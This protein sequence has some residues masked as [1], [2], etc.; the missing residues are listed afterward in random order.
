MTILRH[1]TPRVT[2]TPSVTGVGPVLEV[3]NLKTHFQTERGMVHAVDGVSLTAEPGKVVGIVGESGSGKT[4]L[5]RS[6]MGLLPRQG[7]FRSGEVLLAGRTISGLPESELRAIRGLE[8]GMV[9]QDSMSSLNPVVKIGRQ[10]TEGLEYHKG[11]HTAEARRLSL[12]LLKSVEVPDPERRLDE[13]PHQLSGGMRQRV[14]IAMALACEPKVLLADEPTTALD[15]TVQAHVLDL[16]KDLQEDR[17]MAMILVT[18]DLGVVA[19]RA[20]EIVVMYAGQVV[21]RAPTRVLFREMQMPYTQALLRSVP[22]IDGPR[23]ATFVTIG[24]RP[25]DLTNPPPGCRFAPRCSRA[26]DRCRSED[27]PL[28]AGRTIGH[29]FACWFP[30]GVG[31]PSREAPLTPTPTPTVG[32]SAE[33][34]EF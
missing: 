15:V 14:A 17:A 4:V 31:S 13:Y 26:Q 8:I 20:D 23:H 30:L 27:P 2:P 18:H 34:R 29:E 10:I 12:A 21:E 32:P 33:R 25:P 6:I 22:R 1:F 3:R 7:V 16:L 5:A 24:G 11:M 19:T 9:F 28:T